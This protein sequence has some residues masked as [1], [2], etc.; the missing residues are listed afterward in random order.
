MPWHCTAPHLTPVLTEAI[1]QLD[2]KV[3]RPSLKWWPSK[4]STQIHSGGVCC[5]PDKAIGVVQA[6][7]YAI[8]HR[9]VKEGLIGLPTTSNQAVQSLQQ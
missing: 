3:L 4:G 8:L 2:C 9:F 5:F 1:L 7:P 6:A